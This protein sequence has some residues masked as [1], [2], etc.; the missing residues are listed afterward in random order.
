MS[1]IRAG[2]A[3]TLVGV[4]VLACAAAVGF[5]ALTGVPLLEDLALT[6]VLLA[7]V[8]VGA[9]IVHRRPGNLV[10]WLLLVAGVAGSI[11]MWADRYA[12]YAH[13]LPGT[14]PATA[15]WAAWYA[16][17]GWGLLIGPLFVF[18]P[19]LY[20]DG[21]LP[22]RRW[23][24]VV[25]AGAALGL[26]QMLADA[27]RPGPMLAM[28]SSPEVQLSTNPL[29]VEALGPYA[30]TVMT[31]GGLAFLPVFF[32]GIVAA[33]V[34][35]WRRSRGVERQ[36]MK[37]FAAAVVVLAGGY[38]LWRILPLPAWGDAAMTLTWVAMPVAVGIAVLRYRLYD[39]DRIISRTVSYALLTG[40]LASVYLAAVLGLSR[41][42]APLGAG[43]ELAVAAATLAA[44]AVFAPARRRIQHAVDRRFNRARY[45][46]ERVVVAFRDRLRAEVG[47]E[48][49]VA[50]TR[51]A[52]AGA[53]QPAQASLWLRSGEV[54]S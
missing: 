45:D 5:A 51:S 1:L 27:L 47:L 44:A 8:A 20:P 16:L 3:W 7:L 21:R 41:L 53:V 4:S 42:L 15:V 35:R 11:L 39:I 28:P 23:W 13:A 31:A 17:W 40:V 33:P 43:S 37:W 10:G 6:P 52:A 2:P 54:A 9:L 18:L 49:V 25:V 30:D 19:L 12:P 38:L 36:Q 48:D 24:P 14:P 26:A 32:L 50:A 34:V 22:S 46:A 29:G